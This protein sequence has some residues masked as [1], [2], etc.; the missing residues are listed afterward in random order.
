VYD[1]EEGD[2]LMADY[3]ICRNLTHCSLIPQM[4]VQIFIS[5]IKTV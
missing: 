2:T 1:F 3:C 5:K 4:D